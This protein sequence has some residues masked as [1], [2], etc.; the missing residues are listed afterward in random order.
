[1]PKKPVDVA[2]HVIKLIDILEA[3]KLK[4]LDR[5]VEAMLTLTSDSAEKPVMPKLQIECLCQ[6]CYAVLVGYGAV[7]C[8]VCG[9]SYGLQTDLSDLASVKARVT[10]TP[11]V[12]PL[13]LYMPGGQRVH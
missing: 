1:M 6:G 5:P 10:A 13:R 7:I 11:R 3:A 4:Q 8:G 9:S 12:K 2:F